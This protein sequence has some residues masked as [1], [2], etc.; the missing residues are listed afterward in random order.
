MKTLSDFVNGASPFIH[1]LSTPRDLNRYYEAYRA[2]AFGIVSSILKEILSKLDPNGFLPV[3][4][5]SFFAEAEAKRRGKVCAREIMRVTP[6]NVAA[7]FREGILGSRVKGVF[8]VAD[9]VREEIDGSVTLL[10]ME[11]VFR[12]VAEAIMTG[13][14][15]RTGNNIVFTSLVAKMRKN[16]MVGRSVGGFKGCL[17][18]ILIRDIIR[19][20]DTKDPRTLKIV[21]NQSVWE[22]PEGQLRFTLLVRRR[23]FDDRDVLCMHTLDAIRDL[24]EFNRVMG[25]M[26]SGVALSSFADRMDPGA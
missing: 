10:G 2:G 12:D 21:D 20:S 18:A 24:S 8:D 14:Y 5:A 3:T 26:R 19:Q 4:N 23:V 6:M 25:I 16:L 22:L 7:D 15:D 13:G 1:L 11:P 17:E 9:I